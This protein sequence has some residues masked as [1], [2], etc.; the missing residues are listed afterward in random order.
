MIFT[1]LKIGGRFIGTGGSFLITVDST[2]KMIPSNDLDLS[3]LLLNGYKFDADIDWGDGLIEHINQTGSNN[4]I[5]HT[6]I[7]SGTKIKGKW[8][9]L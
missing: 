6:Y 2:I 1:R 4:H 7:D 9:A 5:S 8:E 3:I